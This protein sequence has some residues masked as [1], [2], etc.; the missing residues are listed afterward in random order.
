MVIN[1]NGNQLRRYGPGGKGRVVVWGVGKV[2]EWGGQYRAAGRTWIPFDSAGR[3]MP[4]DA[5]ET[6]G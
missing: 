1:Q 6:S 4:S 3:L 5:K 2:L